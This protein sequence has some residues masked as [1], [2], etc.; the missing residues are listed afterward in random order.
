MDGLKQNFITAHVL[1]LSRTDGQLTIE[2]DAYGKEVENILQQE[3]QNGEL[4]PVDYWS[5]TLKDAKK[6]HN[7]TQK[8]FLTAV[9]AILLL[10]PYVKGS[11]IV[12]RK[13]HQALKW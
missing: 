9:W 7:T 2:T 4:R 8:E 13:D 10:R 6:N 3:Q 12:V 1:A 5:R 11:R